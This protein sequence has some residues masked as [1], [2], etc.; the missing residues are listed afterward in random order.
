MSIREHEEPEMT[1][2]DYNPEDA[3]T[4]LAIYRRYRDAVREEMERVGLSA[5][6]A[7][8]EV[9]AV[10]FDAMKAVVALPPDAPLGPHLFAF[11]RRAAERLNG[12]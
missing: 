9:G 5:V 7:E 4:F 8:Q 3:E 10:F 11:A 12:G 2:S 6:A 1:R